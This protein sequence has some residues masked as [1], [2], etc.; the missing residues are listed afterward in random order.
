MK[1]KCIQCGK[2]REDFPYLAKKRKYCSAKCQMFY[3]Y[4][5]GIRDPFKIIKKA[6]KASQKRMKNDKCHVKNEFVFLK[7]KNIK[8]I[9]TKSE[10]YNFS[11]AEDESY[12]A[13]D[14]I[15]H[16]CRSRIVAVLEDN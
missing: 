12:V 13:N 5:N 7:V 8:Q 4:E 11:V 16:N 3:E 6:I 9:P 1:W 14:I 10:V 2:E 15:V